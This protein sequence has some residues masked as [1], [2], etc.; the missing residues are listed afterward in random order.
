MPR[1]EC[2]PCIAAFREELPQFYASINTDQKGEH[3]P[4]EDYQRPPILLLIGCCH[5]PPPPPSAGFGNVPSL[6]PLCRASNR[7]NTLCPTW[8][9]D[10]PE[11]THHLRGELGDRAQH[12]KPSTQEVLG[13]ASKR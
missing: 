6:S 2:L 10:H 13:H 8:A 11:D 9:P 5:V 3:H 12:L 1:L 4:V 7:E